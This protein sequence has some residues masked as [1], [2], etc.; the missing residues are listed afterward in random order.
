MSD[1]QQLRMTHLQEPWQA[2]R[3]EKRKVIQDPIYGTIFVEP[4][5]LKLVDT[6]YFQRLRSLK[7]LGTCQYLY[8]S[9]EHTRF[10]HSL[11]VYHL[12][13]KL[14]DTIEKQVAP[15]FETDD[16]R[17]AYHDAC[18]LVKVAGLCH[19]IGHGPCSH[20]FE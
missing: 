4:F 9:A 14:L 11:G 10:E 3:S 1:E 13:S 12:T 15:T 19:D 16:E 5:I 17:G 8:P 6:R 18:R 2:Q 7:Q 20:M